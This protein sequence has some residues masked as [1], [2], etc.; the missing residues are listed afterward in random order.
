MAGASTIIPMPE[1]HGTLINHVSFD[2]ATHH[3][4]PMYNTEHLTAHFYYISEQEKQAIKASSPAMEVL[5]PAEFHPK[6]YIPTPGGADRMGKHWPDTTAE[7]LHGKPF[8]RSLVVGSYNGEFI[9]IE[10]LI[11]MEFLK[12]KPNSEWPVKDQAKVQRAGFY[13]S[14][15][16]LSYDQTSKLYSLTFKN[17]NKRSN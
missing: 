10:P 8:K 9:F 7:E 2:Y 13:P 3:H 6:D 11:N 4:A 16:A 1:G 12:S 17:L 15:Y 14:I 5:P